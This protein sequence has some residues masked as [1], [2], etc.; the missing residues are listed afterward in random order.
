[1]KKL[2][3]AS[4]I[5]FVISIILKLLRWPAGDIMSIISILCV[6][7]FTI[8]NT[9]NKHIVYNIKAFE[10]WV[11]LSWSVYLLFRY[12]HWYSGPLILGMTPVLLIALLMTVIYGVILTTKYKSISKIIIV[13]GGIGIT[14]S[15]IPSY[16]IYYFFALNEVFNKENYI[17]N[18]YS[19]DTYSWC[20]YIYGK[21]VEALEA[22]KKALLAMEKYKENNEI[23]TFEELQFEI[24]KKRKEVILNHTWVGGPVP[25]YMSDMIKS[26]SYKK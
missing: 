10:G 12:L 15:F 18:Y 24:L 13:V 21:D 17:T 25:Q 1:M 5:L 16:S 9:F 19:W 2:L 20:L 6:F 23:G 26:G 8:R 4:V 22:N 7:I 14:C 11:I 3:N